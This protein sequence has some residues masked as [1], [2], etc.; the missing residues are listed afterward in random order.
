MSEPHDPDLDSSAAGDSSS[1]KPGSGTGSGGGRS[2]LFDD[3]AGVAS[4]AFSAMAGLRDEVAA[5]VR[6]RVDE[7]V[8]RLDLVRRDEIE[9][10]REMAS[11]ARAGQEDAEARIKVLE[12]RLAALEARLDAHPGL[13]IKPVQS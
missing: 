2:R 11:R 8:R 13:Q 4:G 7:A 1:F 3:L 9:A 12:T 6:G 5:V 10:V